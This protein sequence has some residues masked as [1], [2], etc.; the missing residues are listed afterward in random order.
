[1]QHGPDLNSLLQHELFVM[2]DRPALAGKKKKK[3][4]TMEGGGEGSMSQHEMIQ[5]INDF[6][7]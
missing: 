6:L 2:T 1:M 5:K 4:I 3:K 7:S